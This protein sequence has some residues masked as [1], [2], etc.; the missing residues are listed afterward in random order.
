MGFTLVEIMVV[1]AIIGL[2]LG[3]AMPSWHRAR[4][5]AQLN[6]IGNNLRLL[7]SAKQQWALENKKASTDMVTTDNLTP[8]M[9]NS[10]MPVSVT[11]ESYQVTTVTDLVTAAYNG[12][13]AGKTGPYTI[14]CF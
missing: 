4:E 3:I 7:E 13:L 5:N 14:T 10:T 2:L 8:Y 6:S 1:V 9:K 11:G 12:V